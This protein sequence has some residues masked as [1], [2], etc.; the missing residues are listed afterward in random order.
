MAKKDM[1]LNFAAVTD[2]KIFGK[3]MTSP[4]DLAA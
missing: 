3:K 2:A 4:L 1:V